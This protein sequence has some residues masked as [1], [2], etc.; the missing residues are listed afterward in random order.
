MND[1]ERLNKPEAY[2]V[3]DERPSNH[4]QKQ[5]LLRVALSLFL[6]AFCIMLVF[7]VK[8]RADAGKNLP[9]NVSIADVRIAR[10]HE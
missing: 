7:V 5:I 8:L 10:K 1:A 9:A 3:Q 2:P 6:L 4:R